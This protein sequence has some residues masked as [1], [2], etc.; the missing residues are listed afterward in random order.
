MYVSNS[1][2]RYGVYIL[3]YDMFLGQS[4]NK[5]IILVAK[6]RKIECKTKEF[7]LFFAE[8]E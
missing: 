2:E 8:M 7:F 1:V 6:L 5:I 3:Q 4:L